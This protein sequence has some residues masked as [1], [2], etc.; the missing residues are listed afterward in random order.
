MKHIKL[1]KDFLTEASGKPVKYVIWDLYSRDNKK[2]ESCSVTFTNKIEYHAQ[3]ANPME[4]HHPK[5]FKIENGRYVRTK[6][7]LDLGVV[8]PSDSYSLRCGL[9]NKILDFLNFWK[10]EG[11][12]L[13][14]DEPIMN[15]ELFDEWINKNKLVKFTKFTLK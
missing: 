4:Q 3:I 9:E 11:Y 13:V 2:V 1:F 14:Y 10:S 12:T 8:P 7:G 5:L 15:K 6:L